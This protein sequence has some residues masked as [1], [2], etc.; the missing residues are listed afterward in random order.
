MTD[1]AEAVRRSKERED[2]R[3]R[4]IEDAEIK[5]IR[6]RAV[7]TRQAARVSAASHQSFMRG[8][9]ANSTRNSSRAHSN[10]QA[11]NNSRSSTW[12]AESIY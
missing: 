11:L 8:D 2:A 6:L 1:V 12:G 5:E 7:N 4:A 3:R 9:N 10:F